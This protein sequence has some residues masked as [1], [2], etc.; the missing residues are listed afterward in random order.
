MIEVD[1]CHVFLWRMME[2]FRL[3]A[4]GEAVT[5]LALKLFGIVKNGLAA[6]LVLV[7][8]RSRAFFLAARSPS[9]LE[10]GARQAICAIVTSI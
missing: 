5:L 8:A 1:C 10:F 6:F 2:T 7:L 9:D 3:N 4:R